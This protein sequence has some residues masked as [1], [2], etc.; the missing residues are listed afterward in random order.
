MLSKKILLP[1]PILLALVSATI[2]VSAATATY[3]TV[4]TTDTSDNVKIEFVAGETVKIHW[5]ASGTVD[6]T[7]TGP[8]GVE[9][10]QTDQPKSGTYN[11][12]PKHVGIYVIDVTGAPAHLIAVG[13]FFVIPVVP[14][15]SIAGIGAM[16]CAVILIK[17]PRKT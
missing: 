15:G 5:S 6:I 4:W 2:L 11:F 7:V 13:T 8:A 3:G 12:L 1:L 17:R 14:Y 9:L 16:L 10:S